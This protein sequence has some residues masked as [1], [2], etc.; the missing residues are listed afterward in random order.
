MV[1]SLSNTKVIF[2]D[3]EFT[4][5]IESDQRS[6]GT[7][8]NLSQPL[9]DKLSGSLAVGYPVRKERIVRRVQ[10]EYP[11]QIVMERKMKDLTT[12]LLQL[13]GRVRSKYSTY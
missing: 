10:D 4:N 11:D 7:S 2:R 1:D 9:S 3:K 12:Q 5:H 6:V 8:N 13:T